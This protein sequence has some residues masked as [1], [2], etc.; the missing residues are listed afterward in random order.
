MRVGRERGEKGRAALARVG[1]L[2]GER[3]IGVDESDV[4]VLD[5]SKIFDKNLEKKIHLQ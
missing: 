4:T 1:A 3:C 2:R 5:W